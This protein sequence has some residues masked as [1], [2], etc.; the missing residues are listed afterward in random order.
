M[1]F[2][3]ETTSC[4]G[5]T[6]EKVRLLVCVTVKNEKR[7]IVMSPTSVKLITKWNVM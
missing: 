5:E 2:T 4:I 3:I 1:K 6:K 7:V